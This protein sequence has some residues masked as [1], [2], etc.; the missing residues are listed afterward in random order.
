[1]PLHTELCLRYRCSIILV[2]TT[3]RG[4][5]A[6]AKPN[7]EHSIRSG[8]LPAISA[9]NPVSFS[10]ILPLTPFNVTTNIN[11]LPG[12]SIASSGLL[13]NLNSILNVITFFFIPPSGFF[14]RLAYPSFLPSPRSVHFVSCLDLPTA[15]HFY[16]Y[17]VLWFI[18][19]PFSISFHCDLFI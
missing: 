9:I 8:Q 16:P 10:P 11:K 3:W 2:I 4:L 17:S 1:M 14:C 6:P 18:F 15:P 19:L 13:G 7:S 5:S 12:Y